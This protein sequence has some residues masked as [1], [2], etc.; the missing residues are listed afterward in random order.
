M[1]SIWTVLLLVGLGFASSIIWLLFYLRQDRNPEPKVLIIK[2]FLMGMIL[3]PW[4]VLAQLLI[5]SRGAEAESVTFFLWA[6][7]IEETIKLLAVRYI[8]MN[9]PN[10]D[11]PVDAMIYMIVA[12]LGFA[13]IENILVLFNTIP[14]GINIAFQLWLLRFFGATLLHVL[15]SALVGYFLAL[16]WF[17]HKHSKILILIGL[18]LG[19][20][21]HFTFNIILVS[22]SPVTALV[23]TSVALVLMLYLIFI[24]FSKIK[25]RR[26]VA[27]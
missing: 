23:Y 10:F 3:T 13:A 20:I 22:F 9:D 26:E 6:A 27:R 1:Y 18:I 2:T 16:A 5:V 21:F 7:L 14:E 8:V 17:Y 25:E 19:T 15:S 24:L 4:A 11:E 12:A